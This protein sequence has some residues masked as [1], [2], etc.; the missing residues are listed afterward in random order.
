MKKIDLDVLKRLYSINSK[1]GKEDDIR[2]EIVAQ[3]AKVAPDAKID[4]DAKGNMMIVKGKDKPY[5]CV[6]AHMDE[7]H[8]ECDD[9]QIV[10]TGKFLY[11]WSDQRRGMVGIGADDK[12]GIYVCLR[13][14]EDLPSVKLIFTVGEEIGGTGS[15][16]LNIDRWLSDV[17]YVIQC[18]R[19]N[20]TDF[21][22]NISGL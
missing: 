12:N 15:N 17:R 10:Q 9:I 1:S 22:T 13:A 7:V 14:L 20:G 18:D 2:D 3:A 11:G 8:M 4:I 6:L 21:I 16:A 19:R 5:P